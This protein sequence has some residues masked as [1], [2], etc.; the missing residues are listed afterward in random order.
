MLISA[1]SMDLAKKTAEQIR[2][3]GEEF[4]Y[5]SLGTDFDKYDGL[6]L[7]KSDASQASNFDP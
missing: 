6:T 3:I 1:E 2:K 5:T 7:Y 4:S